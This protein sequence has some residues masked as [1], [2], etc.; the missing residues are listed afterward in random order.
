[1]VHFRKNERLLKCTGVLPPLLLQHRRWATLK[2]ASDRI[3][4]GRQV[5]SQE[6][7]W[8]ARKK[9]GNKKA[10]AASHLSNGMTVINLHTGDVCSLLRSKD[11]PL[12]LRH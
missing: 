1:M 7:V 6:N 9:A 4:K 10:L 8:V 11:I 5:R 2:S 12:R 3:P